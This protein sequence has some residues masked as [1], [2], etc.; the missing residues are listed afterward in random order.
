MNRRAVQ[1]TVVLRY[2]GSHFK[3]RRHVGLF[4]AELRPLIDRGWSCHVVVD[5]QPDDPAWLDELLNM[6][7]HIEC[8]RRPRG[9][10]DSRNVWRVYRLCRRIGATILHCDNLHTSPLLGAFLARV[11][12]RIWSKRSMNSH[13]EE[14]REPTFRER[15]ALSTKLSCLLTTKVMAVSNAVKSELLAL[16]VPADKILL[17]HN[18]RRLVPLM[19]SAREATRKNWGVAEADVVILTIGHAAPVKGWD[20]LLRAFCRVAEVEPRARLV[21]VGSYSVGGEEPF[22][23]EINRYIT[24]PPLRGKVFFTGHISSVEAA[25]QSADIYVS[26]SRSEGFS[27]ALI[28]ALDAKL[29]CVASR[30][31]IAEDVIRPGVNGLLFDRGDEGALSGALTRLASDDE[32]RKQFARQARVPTCIATVKEYAER[33]ALDYE[34]LLTASAP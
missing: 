26:P 18:P 8:E 23:A 33:M 5:R 34:S 20:L 30:V 16:S 3:S 27:Y 25:L 17:R 12:V 24:T 21:L 28:E 31:G 2:W 19:E 9:N 7:I 6:G 11:P 4:T 13:F 14:C 29:P 22:N 1:E 15:L 10:F 32:I